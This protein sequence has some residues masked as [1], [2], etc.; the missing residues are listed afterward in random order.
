MTAH[1][2]ARIASLLGARQFP[3]VCFLGFI[4]VRVALVLLVPVSP[5]SDAGWYYDRAI[6]LSSEGRYWEGGHPTAYWPI[7][8]PAFLGAIFVVTGPSLLAAKLANLS[9]AG[10]TFWLLYKWTKDSLGQE[11]VS[12]GA[13]LLLTIYPNSV[14]YVPLV[15]TETLYTALVLLG[16]VFLRSRQASARLFGAGAVFGLATL[17]KTQTILLIP[18]LALLA[19]WKRWSLRMLPAAIRES[20]VVFLVA[21]AVV[22]PWSIRNYRTFGTFILVSTNGGMSLLAGN[23]P[24]TVGDYWHDFSTT[25]PLFGDVRFSVADQINANRRASEL[26]RAWIMQNPAQFIGLIPKKIFRLW[27]PNGEAEWQYQA[28]TPFYDEHYRWFRAVRVLNQA[29][30]GAVLLSSLLAVWR[31]FRLAAPPPQWY[32]IA[33]AVIFTLISVIFS[34]QSRYHFP[35]MPFLLAYSAWVLVEKA[36]FPSDRPTVEN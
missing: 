24:S 11:L 31:L 8:Y 30:Y 23:N 19:F 28:G 36:R 7:G 33:V 25:D 1:F 6:T 3:T 21:V 16:T 35:A 5:S 10:V 13:L 20:V 2:S 17:V 9:L 26:A 34:G 29:F 12:R 4:A 15:L 32:G 18:A 14:A 22:V 27:A